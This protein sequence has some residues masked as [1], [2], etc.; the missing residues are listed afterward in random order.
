MTTNEKRNMNI[1]FDITLESIEVDLKGW[2]KTLFREHIIRPM[3][4]I[5]EYDTRKGDD[6]VTSAT[7]RTNST[8]EY[9]NWTFLD[10]FCGQ[11]PER[12]WLP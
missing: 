8:R 10:R 4:K 2:L 1:Q 7:R 3:T 9:G 11:R 6:R 5:A 12:R